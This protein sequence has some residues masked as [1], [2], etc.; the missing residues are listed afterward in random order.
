MRETAFHPPLFGTPPINHL[1]GRG[2]GYFSMDRAQPPSSPRVRGRGKDTQRGSV[3]EW[4]FLQKKEWTVSVD[5]RVH[6]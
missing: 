5:L 1:G 3:S 4:P 6:V 2:C